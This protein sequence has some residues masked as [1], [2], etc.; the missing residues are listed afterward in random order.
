MALQQYYRKHAHKEPNKAIIKV[1]HKLLSR[2]RAVI[3]SGIPYQ[4]GVCKININYIKLTI[5][6][7]QKQTAK[8]EEWHC[9]KRERPQRKAGSCFLLN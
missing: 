4:P 9:N 7:K 1:A 2:M 6:H 8:H 3:N 5:K